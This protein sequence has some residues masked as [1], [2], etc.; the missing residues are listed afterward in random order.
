MLA[1]MV[2]ETITEQYY[3]SG[4]LTLTKN[5]GKTFQ[6]ERAAINRKNDCQFYADRF[7]PNSNY[8][9]VVVVVELVNEQILN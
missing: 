4:R 7:Y 6:T 3:I 8:N 5:L 9:F 2:K 1:Y